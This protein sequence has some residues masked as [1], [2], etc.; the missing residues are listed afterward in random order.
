M[1][2]C[3]PMERISAKWILNTSNA[4]GEYTVG[5]QNPRRPWAAAALAAAGNWQQGVQQ[6]ITAGSYAKG[7]SAA[8]DSA[9]S[10]GAVSK[11]PGRWAEG[12]R[13]GEPNYVKGFSPIR[14]AIASATLPP[15]YARRDP[16]NLERVK[17]INL[18]VIAA[19]RK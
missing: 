10:L 11:G 9:W 19:A 2:A 15:R 14:S 3:K 12:V 13:I 4:T 16:R 18:A 7:V 17:A 5:V 8:G 1:V 6:A